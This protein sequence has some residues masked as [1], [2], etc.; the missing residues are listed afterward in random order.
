MR[1]GI[2]PSFHY[3]LLHYSIPFSKKGTLSASECLK[4]RKLGLLLQNRLFRG[5]CDAEFHDALRGNRDDLAFLRP[6]LHRHLARGNLS[7]DQLADAWQRESVFGV[8]I[9][10]LRDV[11][12]NLRRLLLA[13]LGFL[14]DARGDL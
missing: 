3:S 4:R 5:L 8:H 13:D 10:Q 12:E 6:E 9:R 14:G 11:I 1:N 2:A 7:E